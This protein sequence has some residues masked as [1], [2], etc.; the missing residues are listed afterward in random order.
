MPIRT[1]IKRYNIIIP[2][3]DGGVEVHKMKEWLRQHPDQ[4]PSGLDANN[5]NSVKLRKGLHRL[6]WSVEETPTEF[7]LFQPN[8]DVSEYAIDSVLGNEE[9]EID[10]EE[11]I[12]TFALEY[13]LRD[14]LA[15]NLGTIRVENQRLRLYVDPHC[16]EGVE[17]PTA[18]GPID[19]LAI[20][21]IGNFVVFELKRA[22]SPDHAI[23]QLARYMGWVSQTIG[24]DVQVRGVIV[25]KAI[26]E[27]LRYSIAVFPNVSLFEYQVKFD[28]M[29]VSSK[30]G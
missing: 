29:P 8:T 11:P 4:I 20:D 9:D 16:R 22:R 21:E 25:A 5:S 15:Q 23:G 2:R 26:T 27:N 12:A 1:P 17:Y 30:I 7:R 14:F 18:V 28:L 24:R 13:Q 6:G 19:I 10:E 3:E